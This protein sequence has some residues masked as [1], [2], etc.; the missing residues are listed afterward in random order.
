MEREGGGGLGRC[1]CAQRRPVIHSCALSPPHAPVPSGLEPRGQ[2][3]L[4]TGCKEDAGELNV[5]KNAAFVIL[6]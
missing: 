2:R 5:N 1:R 4:G 3:S 6:K